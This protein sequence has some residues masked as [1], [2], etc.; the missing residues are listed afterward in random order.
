MVHTRPTVVL[1]HSVLGV[2]RGVLEAA[3]V[4]ERAGYPVR[5]VD[6]Y[7]GRVFDDYDEA[8][9]FAESIGY[10]ALMQRAVQA[11][12]DLSGPLLLAGFSNGAGM[13]EFVALQRPAD[14]VAVVQFSGALPLEVIGASSWPGIGVQV[15]YSVG[16][17]FR[18]GWVET[19]V[20]Q[21]KAGGGVV[22]PHL[23]YPGDGHLFTDASLPAEFDP[24]STELLWKRVLEFTER[25][26]D[27]PDD[28]SAR[29]G[30]PPQ[31]R[32]GSV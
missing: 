17:P 3:R 1:F 32:A 19:F 4:F 12:E 10:P 30:E 22:E 5:V 7:D 31:M 20:S 15:H 29:L 8:G 16:D 28:R 27:G 13:A 23:D 21:A 25:M 11:A 24:A 18:T 26:A 14:A 2:R 9:A 6:Q